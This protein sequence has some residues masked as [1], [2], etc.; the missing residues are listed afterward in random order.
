MTR[1]DGSILPLTIAYAL[2]ALAAILVCV[3]ATSLYLTQKRLDGWADAAA[4]AAADEFTLE[5]SSG[6]PHARLTDADVARGAAALLASAG[7][8]AVVVTAASPDGTSARVT[9][10]DTWRPPVLTLFVPDGIALQ[11]TATSRSALR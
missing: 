8:A 10:A 9:L 7:A 5:V 11:S 2:I 4:L 1:D 6:E 3:D